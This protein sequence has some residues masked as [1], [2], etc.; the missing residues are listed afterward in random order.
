MCRVL[1]GFTKGARK[2][3]MK[4]K[5]QE[6]TNAITVVLT[7]VLL[8]V[9]LNLLGITCPIKYITGISC[10]GCGMTRAYLSLFCFDFGSA[11]DFHPLW[12]AVPLFLIFLFLFRKNGKA[13]RILIAI[14]VI[15]FVFV[16]FIRI[17]NN[18]NAVVVF[19]YKNG[20]LYRLFSELIKFFQKGEII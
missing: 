13:K 9:A 17:T 14:S 16:Y 6:F 10:P 4:L 1:I 20:L 18:Y 5:N 11:V 12:W 8:Y 3:T 2:Y 7:V 19:D 15:V